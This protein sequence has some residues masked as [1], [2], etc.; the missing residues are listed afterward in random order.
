MKDL[1][2]TETEKNLWTAFA[3]ESQARSKYTF[4]AQEAKKAG[5][6]QIANIFMETAE[7]ELQHAKQLFKYL[8]GIKD[9]PANLKAAAEGENYE[10]IKMYK[11]FAETADKEGFPEIANTLR[12]IGSVEEGHEKRY[13]KL[14]ENIKDDKVF[15]RE[16]EVTWKCSNCGYLHDGQEP[17][18]VCPACAHPKGFYE[19]FTEP[20]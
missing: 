15:Q 6:V 17:P 11:E 2:G 16:E 5:Y 8:G 14:L 13:L 3:G 20:Y 7:H 1:K 9:T 4:F 10:Y 18:E 19:L 12:S